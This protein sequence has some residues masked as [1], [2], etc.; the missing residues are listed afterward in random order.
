M[1]SSSPMLSLGEFLGLDWIPQR[2]P[3]SQE[4]ALK[5]R[6]AQGAAVQSG[7]RVRG[8][9]RACQHSGSQSN[10]SEE[11]V[12]QE[13]PVCTGHQLGLHGHMALQRFYP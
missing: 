1:V 13:G 10:S 4:E 2:N 9:P 3:D 5:D 11:S 7:R 6:V 12:C 8:L